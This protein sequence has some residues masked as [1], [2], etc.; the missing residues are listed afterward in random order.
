MTEEALAA[1]RLDAEGSRAISEMRRLAVS[2]GP[3]LDAQIVRLEKVTEKI[4]GYIA[5]RPEKMGQI[6]RFMNYYL[7]TVLKLLNAYDRMDDAGVA[8][9]NIENTKGR[10]EEILETVALSFDKQLDALF[11]DEAMDLAADITVL[12]QMLAREGMGGTQLPI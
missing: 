9:V 4:I 6:Q 5:E 1:A 7:P 3:P 8:G 11:G 12:E 10:I 2:I